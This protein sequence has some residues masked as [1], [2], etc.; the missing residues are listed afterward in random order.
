MKMHH[1]VL[2]TKKMIELS[3]PELSILANKID[4]SMNMWYQ[5][6]AK[7]IFNNNLEPTITI[8]S[9]LTTAKNWKDL[10]KWEMREYNIV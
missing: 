4:H 3:D 2:Y 6:I 5:N 1:L 9:K 10:K 8:Q 7:S